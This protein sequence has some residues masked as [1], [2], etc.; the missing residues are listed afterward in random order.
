MWLPSNPRLHRP[1]YTPLSRKPLG[2]RTL[3]AMTPTM[4]KCIFFGD[5][6]GSVGRRRY[7]NGIRCG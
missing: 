6:A 4:G 2:W 7:S 1:P 3:T 5:K